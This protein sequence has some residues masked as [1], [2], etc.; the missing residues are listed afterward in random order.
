MLAAE[1]I[2]I[3]RRPVSAK[4]VTACGIGPGERKLRKKQDWQ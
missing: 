2:T 3:R 1:H 4:V